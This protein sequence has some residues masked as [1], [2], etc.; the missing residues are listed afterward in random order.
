MIQQHPNSYTPAVSK[1][2]TLLLDVSFAVIS[3]ILLSVHI[4]KSMNVSCH[5]HKHKENFCRFSEAK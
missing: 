4:K 3:I 5:K 1:Q 2:R